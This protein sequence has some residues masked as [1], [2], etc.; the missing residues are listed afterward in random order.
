[1]IRK[2]TA[3]PVERDRSRSS[4]P[5][6]L[7]SFLVIVLLGC[8]HPIAYVPFAPCTAVPSE[9]LPGASRFSGANQLSS[10]LRVLH[11]PV[12][13]GP[14]LAPRTV[15]RLTI[16]GES[17]GMNVI[18]IERS[19]TRYRAF[20]FRDPD[21]I[22]PDCPA[23][24]RLLSGWVRALYRQEREVAATEWVEVRKLL[25]ATG[26]EQAPTIEVQPFRTA[27][28]NGEEVENDSRTVF[29]DGGGGLLLEF[30][31]QDHY[32]AVFRRAPSR[33]SDPDARVALCRKLL[34][35]SPLAED[36]EAVF[37]CR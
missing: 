10:Y 35:I 13:H 19:G 15:L 28:V 7:L 2:E 26:F 4:S 37:N 6:P 12:L 36:P 14:K 32:H 33:F 3:D 17:G 22:P 23:R 29:A 11:E 25:E 31:D 34:S 21:F 30:R 18:R 24:L 5:G 20:G 27:T 16:T 1:M 8:S 9:Y